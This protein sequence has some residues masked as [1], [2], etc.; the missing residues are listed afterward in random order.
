MNNKLKN[1]V[2]GLCIV[3]ASG[4]VQLPIG[5]GCG[6]DCRLYYR[7]LDDEPGQHWPTDRPE[8]RITAGTSTATGSFTSS[9]LSG[10]FNPV[11]P[12]RSS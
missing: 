3:S 1:C 8:G 11:K 12:P 9:D 7:Q 6:E 10:I 4:P 2:C 5:S